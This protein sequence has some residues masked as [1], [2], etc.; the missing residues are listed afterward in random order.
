M[1][2][3]FKQ[4][5]DSVKLNDVITVRGENR[6]ITKHLRIIKELSS[7]QRTRVKTDLCLTEEVYMFAIQ[8]GDSLSSCL[9][10]I[11]MDQVI[12]NVI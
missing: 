12:R 10:N 11:V 4:T 5:F 1:F 7:N 2:C 9:F 3:R 6:V 8:Q